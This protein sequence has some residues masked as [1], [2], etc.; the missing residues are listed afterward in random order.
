M[1]DGYIIGISEIWTK[2]EKVRQLL[3]KK[4]VRNIKQRIPEAH[5]EVRRGRIILRPFKEEFTEILLKTFGIRYFS[6]VYIVPTKDEE[7]AKK[8]G[9]LAEKIKSK[10]F[11][12]EVKRVWKGYPKVSLEIER[13][14]GSL[15]L[16]KNPNLKVDVKTPM[17][18]VNVEIHHDITLIFYERIEGYDGYPIGTQGKSLSLFSGGIDSPVAAWLMAKRGVHVDLLFL[19]LAGE[20]HRGAVCKVYNKLLDW[21]PRAK[22]YEVDGMPLI[23][24]II[25]NVKSG[26]RQIVFKVYLYK[27]AEAVADK[28]GIDT[29]VTGESIGQ[30]STQ[31]L[32]SLTLLDKYANK[33][34]LRPLLA[35]NKEEIKGLAKI[36]GTLELSEKVPEVCMLEKHA[37]ANPKA[38]IL[39]QEVNKVKFS[40][41]SILETLTEVDCSQ[42]ISY[43]DFIPLNVKPESLTI[44]DVKKVKDVPESPSRKYLFVCMTGTSA[45]AYAKRFREKGIEAYAL[46]YKT[47]RRLG[48]LK[49]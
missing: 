35:Y 44:I 2:S 37:T 22:L 32:D 29:L 17:T 3:I 21:V 27:I 4:L 48:F 25:Q 40:I 42:S 33:S 9:E 6:P 18:T 34:F 23:E 26:Y 20:V 36:I 1:Y 31:T 14:L 12:V 38:S 45:F 30:V 24:S 43:A 7:I 5:F 49:D 13:A 47:A 16:E 46:D 8:C 39:R 19:N 10:T 28:L 41:D 11:K 15:M